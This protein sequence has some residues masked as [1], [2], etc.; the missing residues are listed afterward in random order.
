MNYI[1]NPSWFYFIDMAS[2]L[3]VIVLL[4]AIVSGFC[5]AVGFIMKL[6]Y[7][8]QYSD[9]YIKDDNEYKV[10]CAIAKYSL[11]IFIVSLAL[12]ILIPT[13]ET[14]ITMMVAKFATYDNA[15]WTLDSVK[16]A[17]DYIVNSI[18]SIS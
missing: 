2:K 6:L 5:W 16:A 1:I 14:I 9:E 4:V 8:G 10:F 12:V 7:E 11:P 15:A 3:F 17:V 18:A 13:K